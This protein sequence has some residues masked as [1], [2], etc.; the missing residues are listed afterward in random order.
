MG[1]VGESKSGLSCT[2]IIP[3]GALNVRV[4]VNA[5]I[6]TYL[7]LLS[8]TYATVTSGEPMTLPNIHAHTCKGAGQIRLAYLTQVQ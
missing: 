5:I 4:I 3:C 7:G 1:V 8:A 2:I 6:D